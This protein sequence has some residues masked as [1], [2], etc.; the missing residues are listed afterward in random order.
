MWKQAN[1]SVFRVGNMKCKNCHSDIDGPFEYQD[2]AVRHIG[3]CLG[4]AEEPETPDVSH[5]LNPLKLNYAATMRLRFIEVVL[6][7]YGHF[8]RSSLMDYFGIS[9]PQAA[10]DIRDYKTLAPG[11]LEYDKGGKRYVKADTFKRFFA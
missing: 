8:N 7:H 11:N 1:S 2:G 3:T 6:D 9:T 10:I 5:D 4:V